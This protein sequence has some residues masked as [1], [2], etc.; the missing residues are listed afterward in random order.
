MN[1]IQKIL[2]MLARVLSRKHSTLLNQTISKQLHQ[3]YP[4]TTQPIPPVEPT[5]QESPP[6]STEDLKE[7]P[8]VSESNGFTITAEQLK[9]IVPTLSENRCKEYLPYLLQTMSEFEINSP[10]R[11]A[12]FIAQ[13]AHESAG[14]SAFLENL[15]YSAQALLNT[16]PKRFTQESAALYARQPEK[17]ANHVYSNRL[18][19][20]DEAN[21]DGW[22]YRGRGVIQTTGRINYKAC[23]IGLNLDLIVSPELLEQP[24]NSFRS[25]GWYWKSRNCNSFADSGD[26]VGLTKAINGGLNGLDDRRVYYTRAKTTFGIS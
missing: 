20:G 3:D 15:N 17:I 16:W 25:A 12:A 10:S 22:R 7:K 5:P 9:R 26:F 18:E 21:G 19:N 4:P 2:E 1:I 6:P 11:V 13:T 23:G 24:L 14:Y 8:P